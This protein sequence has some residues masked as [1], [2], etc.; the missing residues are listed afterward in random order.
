MRIAMIF[1]LTLS[2]VAFAQRPP[3]RDQAPAALF[4]DLK[5]AGDTPGVRFFATLP[6]QARQALNK[7]GQAVLDQ[8][9]KSDGPA[10]I[11]AV[12]RFD[13]PIDEVW[14]IISRPSEQQSYLPHVT[15]SKTVGDRT[16]DGES[17]DFVVSF[18]FTFRYRTQHWFYPE[19]KR[20]EWSLDPKGGDGLTEQLGYWQLYRLDDKHTIG[21]YGTR[22]VV[23]GALL[24]FLRS[25]GE[26]GGVRD[27]LTAFRQHV[28]AAKP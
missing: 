17:V 8:S 6:E 23:R 24:N 16:A 28:D 7:D 15:Q 27:A 12:A 19:D 21:E 14:A 10:L 18:L 11:R 4:A 9:A 26:R 20:L 5:G 25:L 22:I 1:G 13:R 2:T 3:A